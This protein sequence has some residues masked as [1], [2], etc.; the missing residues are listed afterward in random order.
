MMRP[1]RKARFRTLNG[2]IF[3]SRVAPTMAVILTLIVTSTICCKSTQTTPPAVPTVSQ[4]MDSESYLEWQIAT[5][6]TTDDL[7]A[8]A[9]RLAELGEDSAALDRID[10]ALCAVLDPP[11]TVAEEPAY[12]DF[13]AG[14]LTA[15]EELEHSLSLSNDGFDDG[16]IPPETEL[17]TDLGVSRTTVRDALSLL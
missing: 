16:R 1:S 7:L 6:A 4:S 12:L 8:E 14:L 5:Q 17:A 9:R 11:D 3:G 13:V 10:E 2:V 15:A